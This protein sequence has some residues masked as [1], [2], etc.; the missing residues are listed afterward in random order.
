MSSNGSSGGEV[1]VMVSC[2]GMFPLM[3]DR[4][5]EEDIIEVLI[6]RQRKQKQTDLTLRQMCEDSVYRGGDNNEPGIPAENFLACLREG[7]KKVN[8]TGKTNIT[9]ASGDTI[10]F[11]FLAVEEPFLVL[12]GD[13]EWVPD[14]RKGALKDGTACGIVR[15][16]FVK[17]GFE[18]TLR[19][20]QS[21]LQDHKLHMSKVRKL[22]AKERDAGRHSITWGGTTEAG[23]KVPGG[24][25]FYRLLAPGCD[26]SRRMILL[27]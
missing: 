26:E 18:V 8:I 22:V 16:K 20:D 1:V 7:G 21:A 17:W 3:M 12:T 5:S 23:Q 2:E 13:Q 9:K 10:L 25:Y 11:D 24:A 27:P 6:R 4:M 19:I 14:V 15:P